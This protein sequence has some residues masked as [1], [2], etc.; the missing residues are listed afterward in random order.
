M[1]QRRDPA[2][3]FDRP[4][5]GRIARCIALQPANPVYGG[6][7]ITAPIST[8]PIAKGIRRVAAG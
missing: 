7:S 5:A 8:A 6:K 1:R 2:G 3:K 4:A